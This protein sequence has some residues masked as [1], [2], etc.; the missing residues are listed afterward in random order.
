MILRTQQAL[1][2]LV[3]TFAKAAPPRP[4]Q[5]AILGAVDDPEAEQGIETLNCEDRR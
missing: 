1:L 5:P 4:A 2:G 3:E